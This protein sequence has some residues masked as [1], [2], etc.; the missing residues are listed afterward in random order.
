MS[1]L[2]RIRRILVG[3]DSSPSSME[4]LRSAISLAA[5]VEAEIEG[6]FVEDSDLVAFSE[7]PFATLTGSLSARQVQMGARELERSLRSQAER[8]RKALK[9]GAEVHALS[10]SFRVVRGNVHE[11]LLEAAKDADLLSLGRAGITAARR[12]S[13]G[14]LAREAACKVSLVLIQ[15]D[16]RAETVVAPVV[17][18]MVDDRRSDALVAVAGSLAAAQQRP[19]VVFIPPG[20]DRQ[21]FIARGREVLERGA[22]GQFSNEM[23]PIRWQDTPDA[24]DSGQQRAL[25]ARALRAAKSGVLVLY[26]DSPFLDQRRVEELVDRSGCSLLLLR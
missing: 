7:L 17:A 14:S 12:A 13:G 25:L 23:P 9:T 15:H 22:I 1:E 2:R 5:L 3:L 19:L 26:A 10:W 8:A 20:V 4:A 16:R 11:E 24:S 18:L 21:R 6:I